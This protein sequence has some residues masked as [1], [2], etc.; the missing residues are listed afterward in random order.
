[1]IYLLAVL[2]GATGAVGDILLYKGA[3]SHSLSCLG[4]G[5]TAWLI[6][7]SLFVVLVWRWQCP[8]SFAFLC[9]A[10]CHLLLV[11]GIDLLQTHAVASRC[12]C[13]GVVFMVVG[14]LMME[15]GNAVTNSNSPEAS[16]LDA[17]GRRSPLSE[18]MPQP[19]RAGN[20]QRQDAAQYNSFI[21]DEIR[22]VLAEHCAR[23][24][25]EATTFRFIGSSIPWTLPSRSA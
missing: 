13:F 24:H 11:V 22:P 15:V 19:E 23:C 14:L 25:A 10:A 5:M 4:M 21:A 3:R 2:I 18:V 1:M 12:H 8:L 17:G 6:S 20:D 7:L 9:S 16:R